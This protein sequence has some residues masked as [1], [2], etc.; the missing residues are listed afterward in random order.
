M[1]CSG[2]TCVVTAK[3]PSL[4]SRPDGLAA[5][6]AHGDFFRRTAQLD[7]SAA[8]TFA[9]GRR[10]A[11]GTAPPGKDDLS[12]PFMRVTRLLE[13]LRAPTDPGPNRDDRRES[14]PGAESLG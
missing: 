13:V 12:V 5:V 7:R 4:T 1:V 14:L 8:A 9:P 6:A 10:A 11:G 3:A 2:N